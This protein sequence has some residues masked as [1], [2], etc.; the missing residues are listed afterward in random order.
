MLGTLCLQIATEITKAIEITINIHPREKTKKKQK[1]KKQIG[2]KKENR[3]EC[4]S[5]QKSTAN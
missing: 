2:H 5:E 1:E 3:N 4:V